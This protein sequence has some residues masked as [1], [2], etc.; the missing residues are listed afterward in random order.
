[1]RFHEYFADGRPP[2]ISFELFPPRNEAAEKNFDAILPELAALAP[3]FMTVT[4]G[5]LG[6]TRDKTL[7]T[8]L[9]VQSACG[10]DCASHLTCVGS[11][12]ADLDGILADLAAQG[13]H[14]IVAL[15]GDPPRSDLASWE[16]PA[17][18]YSHGNELVAHIRDFESRRG[19]RLF[20]VAVAGYPEKHIEAKTFEADLGFLKRKVEAGADLVITQ[21]FYDNASYYRFVEA[22]RGTGIT[23][24]I[25]PGLMP[26]LSTKQIVRITRMC[27]ATLPAGL[28]EELEA[29]R[30][31]DA[32][33]QA[34]GVRQCIAQ[35]QDLLDHGAPGIHFYV[36]NRANQMARIMEAVRP[37]VS[38]PATAPVSA[39]APRRSSSSP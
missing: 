27:G 9:R 22:A 32:A 8:I 4:Y 24:P 34:I 14:N 33:A 38:Q 37:R 3:D 15:R 29:A 20:G 18:G 1:M 12:R 10:L 36:L 6:S 17:D 26:I 35:A 5:A 23:V 39:D 7:E 2:V 25:I 19:E 11:T 21:L 30:E 13:V 31:D 16:K 28:Q